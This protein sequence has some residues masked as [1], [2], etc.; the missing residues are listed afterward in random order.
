M[1]ESEHP[2]GLGSGHGGGLLL[3]YQ[4]HHQLP[5]RP[6]WHQVPRKESRGSTGWR[7]TRESS[8]LVHI[9]KSS[10][11]CTHLAPGECGPITT[12]VQTKALEFTADPGKIRHLFSWARE[13][14]AL[15]Q[16]QGW[17]RGRQ[18]RIPQACVLTLGLL[19]KHKGWVASWCWGL[20]TDLAV[21]LSLP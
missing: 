9:K 5:T 17:D 6:D 16:V 18:R 21:G 1:L 11:S 20:A 15:E 12:A 8:K 19:G 4:P 14:A 7:R 2:G 3:G 10:W 13:G